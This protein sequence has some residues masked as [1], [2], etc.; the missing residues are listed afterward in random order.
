M[1]L[2]VCKRRVVGQMQSANIARTARARTPYCIA[3]PLSRCPRHS[4]QTTAAAN[5][6]LQLDGRF[7]KPFYHGEDKR[8]RRREVDL[9]RVS[10]I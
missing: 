5:S 1:S 3:S 4:R 2:L 10:Q 7:N 8:T 6:R 9:R